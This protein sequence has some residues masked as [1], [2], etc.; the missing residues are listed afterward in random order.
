LKA[1][2]IPLVFMAEGVVEA[3]RALK[4]L[5]FVLVRLVVIFAMDFKVVV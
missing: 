5:L 3:V 1:V 2:H 4:L